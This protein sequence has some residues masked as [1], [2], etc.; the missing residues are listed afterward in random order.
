[1]NVQ[2]VV[3][4]RLANQRLAKNGLETAREVVAW[5]G[6]VQAQEFAMSKWAL[7]LRMT[8]ATNELVEGALNRREILRTHVLRPTWH[9][10]ASA[11]LRWML[12]LTGPR[13]LAKAVG[14]FRQLELDEETFRRS[15]D[16]FARALA[17]E[18][19]L[20]RD[21][22]RERLEANGVSAGGQRMPYLL[23]QAE[24]TG[25]LVSGPRKGKNHS[26]MLLEER[27]PPFPTLPREEAIGELARRYFHSRGPATLKD[28][29]WWSGLTAGDARAAVA[30]NAG[31]LFEERV[32]G[33][34]YWFADSGLPVP[35]LPAAL[36][37]PAFD[38][39]MVAYTDRSVHM[40]RLG[41]EP[42]GLR[43]GGIMQNL[44]LAGGQVT[45]TW[46]RTE[47]KSRIEIRLNHLAGLE[48]AGDA[49]LADAIQ[50]FGAFYGLPAVL[51]P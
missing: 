12:A 37:L 40:K 23:M 38:E 18:N 20:T 11:D 4:R 46:S 9:Y 43:G 42:P 39:L 22:L 29:C 47:R 49:A 21:E 10:V 31:V 15:Q 16:V 50:R 8:E 25:L 34:T 2:E 45:A 28:F 1:M 36:L 44:V 13:V 24:M 51:V 17:G 14:R 41:Q 19:A 6:A 3:Q 26:Y 30:A 33:K 5:L 32:N 27:V 35:G 7:G 48:S